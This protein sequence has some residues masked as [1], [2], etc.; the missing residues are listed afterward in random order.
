MKFDQYDEE[1]VP[2]QLIATNE[3]L[4]KLSEAIKLLVNSIYDNDGRV[5]DIADKKGRERL[6]NAIKSIPKEIP[7]ALKDK[8]RFILEKSTKSLNKFNHLF[9]WAIGLGSL[10]IALTFI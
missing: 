2:N 4:N 6:E 7:T 5:I 3:E 10:G 8:D 1:Q 9:W